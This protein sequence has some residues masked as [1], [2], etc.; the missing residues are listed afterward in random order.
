LRRD[1]QFGLND[2]IPDHAVFRVDDFRNSPDVHEALKAIAGGKASITGRQLEDSLTMVSAAF[3]EAARAG[4]I[5]GAGVLKNA[6]R[7]LDLEGG[8][9]SDHLSQAETTYALALAQGKGVG[10]L[11]RALAPFI[12]GHATWTQS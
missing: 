1:I 2:P 4:F 9:W 10:D 7:W 3:H 6:G 12:T 5:P 11:V 8:P